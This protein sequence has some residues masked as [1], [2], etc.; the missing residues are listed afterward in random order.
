MGR[1]WE[2]EQKQADERQTGAET[3][4]GTETRAVVE[5]GTGTGM[6]TGAGM[7]TGSETESVR[8]CTDKGRRRDLCYLLHQK[9]SRIIGQVLAFRVRHHLCRQGVAPA[10]S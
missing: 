2:R 6:G 5:T 10:G 1:E 3:E 8:E 4:T 7:G 9:R